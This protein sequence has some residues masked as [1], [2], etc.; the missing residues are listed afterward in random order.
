MRKPWAYNPKIVGFIEGTLIKAQGF[1]ISFLRYVCLQFD[2]DRIYLQ[3][4]P[5]FLRRT[6]YRPGLGSELEVRW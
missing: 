3:T 5:I 1:L 4:G 6:L 2:F